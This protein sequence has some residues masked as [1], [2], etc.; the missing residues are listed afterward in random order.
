MTDD[1]L[2]TSEGTVTASLPWPG[3]RTSPWLGTS[4]AAMGG[5]LVAIG[6]VALGTDLGSGDDNFNQ[7]PGIALSVVMVA[8]SLALVSRLP[9]ASKGA[10]LGAAAAGIPVLTGFVLLSDASSFDDLRAFQILTIIGWL[11]VF[12]LGPLR[13]RTVFLGLAL[14]VAWQFAI[15]EVSNIEDGGL[16]WYAPDGF[17][18]TTESDFDSSS[19]FDFETDSDCD[20]II[21][22][23]DATPFGDS[24]TDTLCVF[25]TGA[26]SSVDFDSSSN[27]PADTRVPIS[28][29]SMAFGFGY[30]FAMRRADRSGQ[31]AIGTAFAATGTIALAVGIIAWGTF[32]ESAGAAG[33]FALVAG[34]FIAWT[35]AGRRRFTTW[36]G[37]LGASIG[38]LLVAG[39]ATSTIDGGG[40]DGSAS[41][42]GVL[43]IAFGVG[44][45][46]IATVLARVLAEPNAGAPIVLG[47]QPPSPTPSDEPPP[48]ELS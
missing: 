2:P 25:D 41:W 27:G 45:A 7:A 24:G 48:V 30:L 23:D 12:F 26:D 6:V 37:A 47:A 18:P 36:F 11:L 29:T 3:E 39:D 34:L 22:S 43:T 46:L 40:G 5:V 19:T 16:F 4:V 14:A 28:L 31:T 21:D 9:G 38:V 42:F 17:I 44:L 13:M 1:A 10:A 35:G 15:V 20:G 8:L 33:F 32:L